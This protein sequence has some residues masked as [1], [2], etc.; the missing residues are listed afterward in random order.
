MTLTQLE[1]YQALKKEER[2]WEQELIGL[3]K[4]HGQNALILP[5]V[6]VLENIERKEERLQ[7]RRK[8]AEQAREDI[9]DFID[10]L[11]DSQLRQIIY[12]HYIA[13]HSWQTTAM[14]I[15]GNNTSDAVRKRVT[16]Y[17]EN[18]A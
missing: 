9:E 4:K 13:G 10:H 17:F 7:R 2:L 3:H 8:R 18:A 16:R 12:Y 11:Q 14:L 15:G 1:Q 5:T 6:D